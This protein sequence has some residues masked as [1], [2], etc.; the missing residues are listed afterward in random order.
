MDSGPESERT[1]PHTEQTSEERTEQ[2][3]ERT[4]EEYWYFLLCIGE[5]IPSKLDT[6]LSPSTID[7]LDLRLE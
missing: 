4:T 5:L 2:T 1:E 3:T 7:T 6:S